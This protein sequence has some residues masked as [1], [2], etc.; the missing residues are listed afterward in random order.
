[1][2]DQ[3]PAD[4][5]PSDRP[6]SDQP[7]AVFPLSFRRAAASEDGQSVYFEVLDGQ[8]N[9]AQLQVPWQN[10]SQ[11]AHLLNQ[12]GVDAAEKRRARGEPNDFQG[13]G[14][15]QIVKGFRVATVPE[16]KMKLVSLFSPSGM[17]ADFALSLDARD[18]QGRTF[19]QALSEELVK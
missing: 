8:N 17:R 6:S 3:S 9:P 14:M 5:P 10:L 11:L 13:V 7:I 4:Q 16:R 1:M 18:S 19:P 15:A 2:S 12:A